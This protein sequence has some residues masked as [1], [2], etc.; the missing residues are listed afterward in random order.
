MPCRM[1]SQLAHLPLDDY[2]EHLNR[3]PSGNGV[4][5]VG[6]D[7]EAG[8]IRAVGIGIWSLGQVDAY[9]AHFRRLAA[10]MRRGGGI[11]RAIADLRDGGVQSPEIDAR[12]AEH[13]QGL[14]QDGDRLAVVVPSSLAKMQV[15]NKLNSTQHAVFISPDAAETWLRA[16]H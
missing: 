3:T 13:K 7:R 15:R 2:I 10:G 4:I 16:Y 12:V 8:V 5:T 11:V 1:A 9:F 14:Y 6:Y